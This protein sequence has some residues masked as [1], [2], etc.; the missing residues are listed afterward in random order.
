MHFDDEP[1]A[2]GTRHA[3]CQLVDVSVDGCT[4]VVDM[5]HLGGDRLE[6]GPADPGEPMTVGLATQ[7]GMPS[8]DL[9]ELRSTLW[10]WNS[11]DGVCEVFVV[12]ADDGK[13]LIFVHGDQVLVIDAQQP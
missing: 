2:H 6:L 7:A 5:V 8:D 13:R 1:L 9:E 10:D 3:T 4:V 11:A 12:P